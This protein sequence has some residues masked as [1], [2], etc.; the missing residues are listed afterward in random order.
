MALPR[1]KPQKTMTNSRYYVV[2]VLRSMKTQKWYIGFTSNLQKRLKQHNYGS[3]TATKR[4]KPWELI[5]AELY[6][7]KRDAM[8]RETFLKSGSGW[9]FLRKQL[10]HF[11]KNEL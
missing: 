2:Y 10:A 7:D 6:L 8:G 1:G 5:Y 3:V 9:K 11:L 4:G